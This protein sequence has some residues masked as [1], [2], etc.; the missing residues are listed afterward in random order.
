MEVLGARGEPGVDARALVRQFEIPDAF[1][2][3]VLEAARQA[4]QR[5]DEGVNEPGRLD[6][7]DRVVV[8][9]PVV[10][11]VSLDG[12]RMEDVFVPVAVASHGQ[13]SSFGPVARMFVTLDLRPPSTPNQAV[14]RGLMG[15]VAGTLRLFGVKP[16]EPV[17]GWDDPTGAP[18]SA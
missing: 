2:E 17:H 16:Y 12:T 9:I 15:L 8:T 11:N 10:V 14:A 13:P 7:R 6:L 1:P 4:T 3:E 18:A 5:L